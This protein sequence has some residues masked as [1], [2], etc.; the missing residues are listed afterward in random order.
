MSSG[1][2]YFNT[3][4]SLSPKNP[5]SKSEYHTILEVSQTLWKLQSLSCSSNNP[6]LTYHTS[7]KRFYMVIKTCG[8]GSNVGGA[9][10]M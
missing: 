9:G 5:V 3:F 4:V 7:Q 2:K 8:Y 10:F 1:C 6:L